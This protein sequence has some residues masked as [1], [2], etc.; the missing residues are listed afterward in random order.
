MKVYI[1]TYD[2]RN[3][4]D[5]EDKEENYDTF[6]G[7]FGSREEAESCIN[8]AI[9]DKTYKARI[10][11]TEEREIAVDVH[12]SQLYPKMLVA[13]DHDLDYGSPDPFPDY[14]NEYFDSDLYSHDDVYK[15]LFNYGPTYWQQNLYYFYIIEKDI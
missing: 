10:A 2:F 12:N 4:E 14:F 5:Y 15:V 6:V 7:V 11:I 1:V 13:L 3:C 8:A 9:K